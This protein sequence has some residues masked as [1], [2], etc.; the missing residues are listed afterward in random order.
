M[1]GQQLCQPMGEGGAPR[2]VPMAASAPRRQQVG[3]R[4]VRQCAASTAREGAHLKP[5]LPSQTTSFARLTVPSR[6]PATKA[7]QQ[8]Q[9]AD[10]AA[11]RPVA[12]QVQM[13]GW[14][15]HICSRGANRQPCL[16]TSRKSAIPKFT[17]GINLSKRLVGA[18]HA[19]Q[20]VALPQA[21]KLPAGR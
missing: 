6:V 13:Y 16:Q 5:R 3:S 8:F 20:A 10:A 21:P 2:V 19:Q 14:R 1:V 9:Q 11:G 15:A 17:T 7:M 18:Q 12:S 4:Q